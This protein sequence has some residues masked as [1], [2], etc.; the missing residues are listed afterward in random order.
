M[1]GG[2]KNGFGL[3]QILITVAIAG[4]LTSVAV[5]LL[6]RRSPADVRKQLA[7]QLN[8]FTQHAW[9]R[10]ITTGK[11][12]QVLFDLAKNR[13][14]ILTETDKVNDAG[15]FIFAPIKQSYLPNSFTWPSTYQIKQFIIEGVD[16]LENFGKTNQLWFF[17]VPQ[18]LAQ[19]VIINMVD[20]ND[21]VGKKPRQIGL[22]LNPFSAQFKIYDSFQK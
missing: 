22:V 12:H 5:P 11:T 1:P 8:T 6:S 4:L 21:L 14:E 2:N 13:I 7:A 15:D 19:A 20:A 18:G 9:Y 17:I 16:M 3:L 10:A